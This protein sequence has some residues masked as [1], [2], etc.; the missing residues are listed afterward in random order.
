[1]DKSNQGVTC[2]E[3]ALFALF[4]LACAVMIYVYLGVALLAGME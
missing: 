1:M 2:G 3:I 4:V